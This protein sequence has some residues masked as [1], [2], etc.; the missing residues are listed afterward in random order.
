M[1]RMLGIEDAGSFQLAMDAMLIASQVAG[2]AGQDKLAQLLAG[3]TNANAL[4]S[5][6]ESYANLNMSNM[7][8]PSSRAA[9]DAIKEEL[10]KRDDPNTTQN[11]G[12]E[13]ATVMRLL[14]ELHGAL[15]AN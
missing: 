13:M 7:N 8:D 12:P 4:I 2:V 3:P 6:I 5:G 9:L 10:R 15:N 14:K 1:M 11:E